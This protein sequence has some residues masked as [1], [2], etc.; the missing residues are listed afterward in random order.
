MAKQLL[1]ILLIF[2]PVLL[3]V[4][5]AQIA[6]LNGGKRDVEPPKLIEAIPANQSNNFNSARIT[7]RFDEFVKLNDLSNQLIVSPKLKTTPEIESDG[8]TI[9]I[10]LIKNELK[11]NTTYRIYLGQAVADMHEANAIRNFEYV[12]STGPYI[13][14]L[15]LKGL[16]LDAFNNKPANNTII[17][18]Y[19]NSE[20][21]DSLPYKNVPDYIAK[22]DENGQFKFTNLP[23]ATFKVYAYSDKNKNY[24]YDGETEKIAFLD[25]DLTL[26]SD[27]TVRF[28][29]FQEES[30]KGFIKKTFLP[31]YGFMQ[32]IL[33][34]KSLITLQPLNPRDKENVF[35]TL[36]NKEKDTVSVYY[37]NV[38]DTLG[39]IFRDQSRQKADTLR[40]T[41]PKKPPLGKKFKSMSLNSSGG[42]LMLGTQPTLSFL[43]W[44]DIQTANPLKISLR[45]REDSL[46]GT[47]PV[48]GKWLDITHYEISSELKEGVNYNMKIDTNAFFDI[49]GISNDSIA[50]SFKT[51][52]RVEY[53]KA[54]LKL[55]FNKKQAYIIELVNDKEQVVRRSFIDLPLSSSNA[56]S[57]DFIDVAPGTYQ[58]KVIYDNNANKKWDTG[59]FLLKTQ[60]EQIFISS[61]QIKVLS[62]WEI[63]EEIS[64]KE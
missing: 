54:T 12:F 55:L 10:L 27:S 44:M 46:I 3:F 35:E 9:T 1:K 2:I 56:A 61:K 16:V 36:M 51:Q 64:I 20:N 32:I 15:E 4:H 6:P 5:C 8:K 21:T 33:N 41:L 26:S 14:S 50:M 49:Y 38:T 47:S 42:A 62:D 31:Y 39:L 25:P 7:L 60:P 57:L 18:L 37:K 34:K 58:V 13:D 48:T 43:N 53:G 19:H 28:K 59:N 52:S 11:P 23:A 17:G 22:S 63:E 30:S 45:S 40:I 24:L 29:L